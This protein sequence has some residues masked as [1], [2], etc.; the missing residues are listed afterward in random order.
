M[1]FGLALQYVQ[2]AIETA[3]KLTAV[4]KK[5][6]DVEFNNMLV[7]LQGQLVDAKTEMLGMKDTIN[8][9]TQE[10]QELKERL[11]TKEKGKPTFDNGVY[12]FD[13]DDGIYCIKCFDTN[14]KK[15]RLINFPQGFDVRYE[16]TVC[17]SHIV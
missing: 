9:L 6:Q 1:D 17:S 3:K 15:H 8:K 14:Q 7:E 11:D 4:S 12:K 10:N 16:C 5:V 13:G 2:G